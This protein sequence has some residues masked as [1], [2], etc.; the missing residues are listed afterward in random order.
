MLPKGIRTDQFQLELHSPN[1]FSILIT[2]TTLCTPSLNILR[3]H[4]VIHTHTYNINSLKIADRH[5]KIQMVNNKFYL[6]NNSVYSLSLH[7]VIYLTN[8]DRNSHSEKESFIL[9]QSLGFLYEF[10]RQNKIYLNRNKCCA[11]WEI[12]DWGYR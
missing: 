9:N 1:A 12:A 8:M 5:C 10:L 6:K 4:S 2:I 3:S 11:Y 7:K